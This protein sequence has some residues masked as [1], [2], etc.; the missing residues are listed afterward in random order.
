MFRHFAVITMA[1]TMTVAMFAKGEGEQ[2]LRA[3]RE[4][5]S[6]QHRTGDRTASRRKLAVRPEVAEQYGSNS[7]G[8]GWG[9]DFDPNF[10]QPMDGDQGN[11]SSV[12]PDDVGLASAR[13][14]L[15]SAQELALLTPDQRAALLSRLKAK[16][17]ID[18]A[19]LAAQREKLFEASRKRSSS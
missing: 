9:R 4:H 6:L 15:P 14:T 12:I 10:G 5:A 1:L 11:S 7:S 16:P 19:V 17:K 13:Q 2:Q 18:P 8:N 3:Q